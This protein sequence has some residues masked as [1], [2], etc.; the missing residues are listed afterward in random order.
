ML[1]P[2]FVAQV[3]VLYKLLYLRVGEPALIAVMHL[4]TP[5]VYIRRGEESDNFVEHIADKRESLFFTRVI[6]EMLPFSLSTSRDLRIAT[7]GGSGMPGHVEFGNNHN[8]AFSCISHNLLDVF[9]CIKGSRCIGVVPV[10]NSSLSR[11]FWITLYL[12]APT[13]FVGQMP[14]EDVH[15]ERSHNIKILFHLLLAKEMAALIEHETAPPVAGTVC[16]LTNIYPPVAKTK[17]LNKS[18]L[19]IKQSRLG[20]GA[21]PYAIRPNRQG[22]SPLLQSATLL[23]L[24]ADRAFFRRRWQT[25]AFQ[26]AS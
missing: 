21:E 5:Y 26:F 16:N 20:R 3:L 12:D 24:Q 15:A 6:G 8:I 10:A 14:M 22:I 13:R 19:S 9:L 4:V 17:E 18:L 7:T 25:D 23:Q 11:Q 1:Q 2:H